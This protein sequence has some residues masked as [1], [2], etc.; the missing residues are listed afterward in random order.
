M[1]KRK[2]KTAGGGAFGRTRRAVPGPGESRADAK[3]R[4][5]VVRFRPNASH[6]RYL[7]AMAWEMVA[8]AGDDKDLYKRADD[9]FEKGPVEPSAHFDAFRRFETIDWELSAEEQ[10]AR[11]AEL[12]VI[13]PD[14]VDAHLR[15]AYLEVEFEQARTH[16]GRAIEAGRRK[17]AAAREDASLPDA[18]RTVLSFG[19]LHALYE[20]VEIL[21]VRSEFAEARAF[22]LELLEADPD[23]SYGVRS[24]LFSLALTEGDEEESGRL[25]AEMSSSRSCAALYGRAF[26]EFFIAIHE[27]PDFAPDMTSE[28][29]FAKLPSP[30]LALAE[31]ALHEAI[32]ES[33]WTAAFLLDRRSLF[34]DSVDAYTEGDPD[35]SLD[36]ARLLYPFC[37]ISKVPALWLC[38]Q[39]GK[40]LEQ[41]ERG[42]LRRRH[43]LFEEIL[44]QLDETDMDEVETV[45]PSDEYEMFDN[46]SEQIVKLLLEV[47][48]ARRGLSGRGRRLR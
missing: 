11:I 37:T 1:G 7:A 29:P 13:D 32:L 19:Y 21:R 42:R 30:R 15:L 25:L 4:E 28:E 43:E 3:D 17:R 5:R 12:L 10:R 40:A 6:E 20:F 45:L 22:Y 34:V 46:I 27:N 18:V 44:G 2:K 36:C 47:G 38:S 48:G 41:V 39:V 8:E 14:C 26:L 24:A 9:R 16:Y 35:E 23:D 33:P 31:A